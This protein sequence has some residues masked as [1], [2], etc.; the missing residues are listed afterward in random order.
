MTRETA[1]G[2]TLNSVALLR[3][4][5]AA[6]ARE[7]EHAASTDPYLLALAS[8]AL[9]IGQRF[10]DSA[11]IAEQAVL[12]A[13][14]P[15]ARA[16]AL[17]AR[18]WAAS[19]LT[20]APANTL[21]E[22][23]GF[24]TSARDTEGIGRDSRAFIEY[25]L[26]ET[27]LGSARLDL[28]AQILADSRPLPDDFLGGR[29]TYLPMMLLIQARLHAFQG[30]ISQAMEIVDATTVSAGTAGD[31]LVAAVRCFLSGNAAQRQSA[32]VIAD[33][34][35][36]ELGEPTDYL[37]ASCY[38][39]VS[40][41][42]VAMGDVAR[43]ATFVLAAGRTAGL[44]G[45]SIIDRAL[46]LE[47]L[48][49][50]A[51]ADGDL[52]AAQAWQVHAEPLLANTIARPTIERLM[53]RVALLAGEPREAAQWAAL[54]VEHASADGR[55][56][57]AAEGEIV[58]S[59]AQMALSERGIAA[60]RLEALAARSVPTGHLA[61]QKS[62]AREL[63]AVGRRLRPIAGTGWHGLSARERDIAMLVA[64]GHG[65]Q[66]I[67]STLH[68]SLHT[69]QAHVSRVLAAFGAASRLSVAAAVAPLLANAEST[70][71]LPALTPRQQAVA[72]LIAR[73]LRN[74][75]I[76][77]DLGVGIKTVEKH[78]SD[79]LRRWQVASRSDIARLALH[80]ERE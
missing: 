76:A 51:V 50:A 66:A 32:R 10:A 20:T 69:V 47:M 41:G 58:L 7:R 65:N 63:R 12:E 62:A 28:A 42:L 48:V 56:I 79:I 21:D 53:S 77:L 15:E 36:A 70:G 68:V 64:E 13:R 52:D 46:G 24:W 37:S 8:F 72:D 59:R 49:A 34:L 39:L 6:R 29:H 54:A 75:A 11:R 5:D 74:D 14:D 1:L 43:A 27:A 44:E 4:L 16:L 2:A 9:C 45:L 57:E 40:Y 25:L 71:E 18:A 31:L 3:P 23:V 33:R 22:A 35:E 55:A 19:T 80:A 78:V 26:A 73:G 67:A 17:A 60:T 38:S 30:R 61:A